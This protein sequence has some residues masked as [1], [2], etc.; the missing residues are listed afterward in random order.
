MIAVRCSTSGGYH[1]SLT[2]CTTRMRLLYQFMSAADAQDGVCAAGN[3]RT[4]RNAHTRHAQRAQALIDLLFLFNVEMRRA[5]VQEREFSA[6]GRA[7]GPATRVVS[8][9]PTMNCPCHRSGY[10][11]PSAW[12]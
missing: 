11:R 5:L 1:T 8:A 10:C 4:M 6:A 9:R 2:N 3:F 7:P 12:P